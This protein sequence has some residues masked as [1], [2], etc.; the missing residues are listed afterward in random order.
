MRKCMQNV[1]IKQ[2]DNNEMKIEP[3]IETDKEQQV[4]LLSEE[5]KNELTS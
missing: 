5:N 3:E 4:E 2:A 1:L